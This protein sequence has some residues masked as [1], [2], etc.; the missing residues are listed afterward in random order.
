MFRHYW[1]VWSH[2]QTHSKLL[3]IKPCHVQNLG[4]FRTRG[5]LKGRRTYQMIM[6]IQR[7]VRT[8]FQAFWCI[9]SHTHR[10]TTKGERGGERNTLIVLGWVKR[11]CQ[12]IVSR[13]SRRKNSKMFPC[14]GLF[15]LFF[16]RNV[17]ESALVPQTLSYAKICHTHNLGIFRSR[18]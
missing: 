12:N 2:S 15:L 8:V 10:R 5:M 9:L 3:H 13:V 7:I 14:G 18:S 4:L 6:H 16:W 11:F 1:G 17:Y